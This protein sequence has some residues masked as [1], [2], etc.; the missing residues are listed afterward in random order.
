M[1]GDGMASLV[2]ELVGTNGISS[3]ALWTEVSHLA[4]LII[5]IFIFAFGLYELRKVLKGGAKGK[6]KF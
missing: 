2:T 1:S 3:S 4:P 6:L 5:I